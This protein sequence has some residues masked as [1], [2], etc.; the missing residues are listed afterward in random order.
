MQ[1]M[2]IRGRMSRRGHRISP[3]AGAVR[4]R[5]EGRIFRFRHRRLGKFQRES[6]ADHESMTRRACLDVGLYEQAR[7]KR[8]ARLRE[9]TEAWAF[10]ARHRQ[11][12]GSWEKKLQRESEADLQSGGIFR[13]R[14]KRLDKAPA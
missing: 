1:G 9:E 4:L 3:A 2:S 6:E 8:A 7:Q 12:I 11:L 5:G 14:H 13:F 10:A